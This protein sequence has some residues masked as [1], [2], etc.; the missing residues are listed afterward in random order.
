[1]AFRIKVMRSDWI[2]VSF[3]R[4]ADSFDVECEK[5]KRYQRLI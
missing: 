5:K 1:M 2:L 3:E 4:F